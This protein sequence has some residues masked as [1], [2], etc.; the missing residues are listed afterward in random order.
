M[1]MQIEYYK[2]EKP[3]LSFNKFL[4]AKDKTALT[5]SDSDGSDNLVNIIAY[6]LMPTHL[7]LILKQTQENG[8][9][10]FMNKILNSYSHYLNIKTKRRGPLWESRFKSILVEDENQLLHLTRYIHL[11]PVTAYLAKTPQDWDFSSYADYLG[12]STIN[13]KLCNFSDIL[14]IKPLNYRDFVESRIEYQRELAK[15]KNL[16]LD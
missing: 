4:R 5:K 10:R 14:D 2:T 3:P 15:I 9:S 6:C 16:L 13:N 1:L 12:L 11:N 8:I 7:H